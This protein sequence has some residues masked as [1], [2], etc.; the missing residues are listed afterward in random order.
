MGFGLC[1]RFIHPHG[2]GMQFLHHIAHQAP[3]AQQVAAKLFDKL[4][5]TRLALGAGC[6]LMGFGNRCADG[7]EVADEQRQRLDLDVLVALQAFG[8][9]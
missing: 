3:A 4:L 6:V 8:L 2:I 5:E 1:Y 9:P 7:E